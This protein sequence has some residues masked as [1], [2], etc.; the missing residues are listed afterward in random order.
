MLTALALATPIFGFALTPPSDADL[1]GGELSLTSPVPS[2]VLVSHDVEEEPPPAGDLDDFA[3]QL[4]AR[5]ELGAIHR[6]FGIATWGAMLATVVL[7]FIQYYN[8]YGAFGGPADTPCVRGEAVFGQDQCY[9]DPW[10]HRIAAW[11]TTA[12]YGTTFVLSLTMPDPSDL[13]HARGDLADHVRIHKALR[14]VHFVGMILQIGLGMVTSQAASWF[15]IDRA[16]NF[17]TLQ[18]LATVHQAI[19]LVTFGTLTVAGAL[20][21]F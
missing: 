8:L 2:F 10:V 19:G 21:I 5:R 15:D 3:A 4:R 20:M 12:L 14:W 11:T 6:G 18:A 7:G 1:A 17:E 13:D 9:G 16:N